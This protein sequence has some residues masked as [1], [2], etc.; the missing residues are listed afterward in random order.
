MKC[1]V[2]RGLVL[3]AGI[4]LGILA[5]AATQAQD[6]N[7]N[8]SVDAADY[9][10]CDMLGTLTNFQADG[11]HNN[12]VESG[13][14]DFWKAQFTTSPLS[15]SQTGGPTLSIVDIGFDV[16][17]NRV[18]SVLV[19]PVDSLFT[20][21]PDLPDRGTGASLA[22]EI[23]FEVTAGTLVSVA[24]NATNFPSDNPGNNPFGFGGSPSVGTT[25]QGN[26]IFAALGSDFFGPF[27]F[28][29][30]MVYPSRC[31]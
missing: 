14:Y 12:F 30:R 11:N 18:W 4:V 10:V 1:T 7:Q 22:A 17:G 21:T 3:C 23:G 31:S 15:P 24:K 20:N 19:D 13:D 2:R 9:T 25:A 16:S 29:Q 28:V 26:R 8:G 5:T 27:N 6:Y